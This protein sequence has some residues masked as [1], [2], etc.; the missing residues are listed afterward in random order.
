[1]KRLTTVLRKTVDAIASD[2][3]QA[4]AA[5]IELAE[6]LT[7]ALPLPATLLRGTGAA[8]VGAAVMDAL[9]STF[10]RRLTLP[11]ALR[12]DLEAFI[13]ARSLSIPCTLQVQ[14]CVLRVL[15]SRSG[16]SSHMTWGLP[17]VPLSHHA[18]T[19]AAVTHAQG[20]LAYATEVAAANSASLRD[21]WGA[22]VIPALMDLLHTF[23]AAT[24]AKGALLWDWGLS[25]PLTLS[26][27]FRAHAPSRAP[28]SAVLARTRATRGLTRMRVQTRMLRLCWACCACWCA[29]RWSWWCAALRTARCS[30]SSRASPSCCGQCCRSAAMSSC[31]WIPWR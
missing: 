14:L 30:R 17:R 6:H 15:R 20:L 8:A 28:H 1:M 13:E 26:H 7:T 2:S 12:T 29:W 11:Q 24:G 16:G 3:T 18:C 4:L 23:W 5:S 10:A 9:A 19:T 25:P 22:A 27:T 21:V 31:R